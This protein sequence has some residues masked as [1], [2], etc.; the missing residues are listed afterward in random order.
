ML[1]MVVNAFEI[2]DVIEAA[3]AVDPKI[4]IAVNKIE[5][6]IGNFYQK[7]LE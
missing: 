4:F 2:E 5:R 3:K 1:Y 6:I 7:P